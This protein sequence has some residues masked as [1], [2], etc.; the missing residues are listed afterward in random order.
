[1]SGVP[2]TE[3]RQQARRKLT[4]ERSDW[5]PAEDDIIR[6]WAVEQAQREAQ[7]AAG[8]APPRGRG[9]DGKLEKI[10]GARLEEMLRHAGFDRSRKAAAER[11]KRLQARDLAGVTERTADNW[12]P[13]ED[14]ALLEAYEQQ[15]QP[16]NPG[17]SKDEFWELVSFQLTQR[18]DP[19]ERLHGACCARWFRLMQ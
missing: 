8:T 2:Q 6:H 14:A 9:A 15:R 5:T 11:W 12:S 18:Q 16:S 1:M 10:K 13:A 4:D 7:L 3:A 17:N 19:V